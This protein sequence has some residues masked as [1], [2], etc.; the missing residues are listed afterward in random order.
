MTDHRLKVQQN[1][2]NTPQKELHHMDLQENFALRT[3]EREEAIQ[4]ITMDPKVYG[5]LLTHHWRGTNEDDEPLRD[6]VQ[7]GSGGSGLYGGWN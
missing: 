5:K 7:I 4:L 3:K 6:G 2:T 1:P